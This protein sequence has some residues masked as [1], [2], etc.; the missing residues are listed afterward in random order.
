MQ[1]SAKC[2][3]KKVKAATRPLY[4]NTSR[5][6]STYSQQ[7]G[8]TT[9]DLHI[10]QRHLVKSVVILAQCSYVVID[11]QDTHQQNPSDHEL[12]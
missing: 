5:S 12:E 6:T 2:S 4:Y 11:L 1:Q 10:F 7:F 9:I 8:E 3:K